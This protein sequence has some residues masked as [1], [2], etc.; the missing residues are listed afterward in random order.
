MLY[1][2]YRREKKL[3]SFGRQRFHI[4]LMHLFGLR[5]YKNKGWIL[6]IFFRY[7]DPTRSINIQMFFVSKMMRHSQISIHIFCVNKMMRH[8]HIF[9]HLQLDMFPQKLKTQPTDHINI[10]K[11]IPNCDRFLNYFQIILTGL[12][13]WL[14]LDPLHRNPRTD[15]LNTEWALKHQF[16]VWSF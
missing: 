9:L 3:L 13:T 14:Q 11:S 1:L 2:E 12:S 6:T 16:W 7:I 4:K 15:F 8:S 5:F 10:Y